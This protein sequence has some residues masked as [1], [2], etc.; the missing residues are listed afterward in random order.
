ML[1]IRRRLRV[2]TSA[3]W[4]RAKEVP[5]PGPAEVRIKVKAIG[6]NR[7]ESMWR[8]DKSEAC[9]ARNRSVLLASGSTL[10]SR[11]DLKS[12][13]TGSNLAC[14]KFLIFAPL[15]TQ[16]VCDLLRGRNRE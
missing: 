3:F 16:G 8:N 9:G 12:L 13:I 4:I 5:A 2:R 14:A 10:Q 1:S 11:I 6:I 7:A 15:K